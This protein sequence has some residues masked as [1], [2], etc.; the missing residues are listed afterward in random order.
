MVAVIA[1][2][3][4]V[5]Y[6]HSVLRSVVRAGDVTI[7]ATVGNGHDTALLAELVGLSGRVYGFDIQTQALESA[8]LRLVNTG[9]NVTLLN[10]GHQDLCAHIPAALHGSVSAVTFNLGYL[11]GG[12]KSRTTTVET[13]TAGVTAALEILAPGGIVTVV[14]YPHPEGQ[15]EYEALRTMLATL[16]QE[17]FTCTDVGFVNHPTASARVLC[18][19]RHGNHLH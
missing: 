10:A 18:I 13:T 16:A 17:E 9:E 12:D 8:R 19:M 1:Y 3:N 7:D 6:V 4:A 5:T 11:P 15:A 14:C 2:R